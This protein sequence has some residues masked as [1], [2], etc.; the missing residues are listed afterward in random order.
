MFSLQLHTELTLR[1]GSLNRVKAHLVYCLNLTQHP[2]SPTK[3]KAE[4][5]VKTLFKLTKV[6][7]DDPQPDSQQFMLS[8]G[9]KNYKFS[10]LSR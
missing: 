6:Q 4:Y 1:V 5:W 7:Q 3:M 2:E 10:F 9:E 8:V